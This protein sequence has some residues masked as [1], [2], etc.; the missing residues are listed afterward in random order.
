MKRK[1]IVQCEM[2]DVIILTIKPVVEHITIKLKYGIILIGVISIGL[3]MSMRK[4]KIILLKK[5]LASLI[6]SG[7]LF[8]IQIL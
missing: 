1:R 5:I 3:A 7:E 8:Q 4:L 6:E 2:W